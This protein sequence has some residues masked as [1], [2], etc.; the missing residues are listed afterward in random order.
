MSDKL[1]NKN[2]KELINLCKE[3]GISKY[4][5]KN[6]SELIEYIINYKNSSI[7]KKDIIMSD[8]KFIDLFCGIGGFHQALKNLN[9]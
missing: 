9:G 7:I 3:L 4:S 8:F 2:K 6:K 1:I 5:S